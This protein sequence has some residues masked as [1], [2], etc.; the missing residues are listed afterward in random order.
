MYY[1]HQYVLTYLSVSGGITDSQTSGIVLQSVAGIDITKPGIAL[2]NYANPLNEELAEWI[3]YD[4]INGSNELVGVTRGAEKGSGKAHANGVAIAFPISETHNNQFADVF[5][6]TATTSLAENVLLK[7][8]ASAPTTPSAGYKKLYVDTD[9]KLYTVNSSGTASEVGSGGQ[10]VQ[11]FKIPGTLAA[12]TDASTTWHLPFDLKIASATAYV[13]TAGTTNATVF[14]IN[15]NGSTIFTDKPSIAS[16]ATSDSATADN[17]TTTR[18]AGGVVTVDIDSVS[19]TP[20]LEATVY[21]FYE[22]A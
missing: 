8:T 20:P 14:D 4:S 2:L 18:T 21:V 12:L 5:H 16:G 3:T 1:A 10:L 13:K 17:P 7:E 9:G 19:T 15:L 11:E 6:P 22:R